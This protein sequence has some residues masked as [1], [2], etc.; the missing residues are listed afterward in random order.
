[1][2]ST[3]R[4]T[5]LAHG[6]AGTALLA[7]SGFA[8]MA[9]AQ[10]PMLGAARPTYRRI[11]LGDFEVTTLLDG[12]RP[13]ADPWQMFGD[14]AGDGPVGQMLAANN[15]PTDFAEFTFIPT[16]VNTGTD[17]ILFDTGIGDGG[18]PD[19]GNLA[20]R[21]VDAGYTPEQVSLVV[22][23]HM[24]PDHIGGLMSGGTPVFSNASYV[25]GRAEYDFF[26]SPDRM[27]SPAEGVHQLVLSNVLPL[28]EKMRFIEA[29]ESVASGID[30]VAAFGHTPGHMAYHVESAGRRFMLTADTANHYV[31]ALQDP[32]IP[33]GFDIDKEAATAARREVFGML[34]ADK[35]PF[36]GYH[37]PFPGMGYVT[38]DG[39]GFRYEP[40]SY[41]LNL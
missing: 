18:Q 40:A 28:A 30:A 14:E 41:Q 24:H 7:T 20:Q 22:L 34:A 13:Q 25:T 23:T 37:M 11:K 26:A 31:I 12:A 35:V 36:V 32:S 15:L 4:R 9:A 5:F 27:G 33:F 2:I 16:L 39:D 8:G 19:T 21:I 3:S 1:M 10:A 29:G 17:L 6:A 38:A